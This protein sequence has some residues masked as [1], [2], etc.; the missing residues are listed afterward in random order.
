[1]RVDRIGNDRLFRKFSDA[2]YKHHGGRNQALTPH[3]HRSHD[4]G[5]LVYFFDKGKLV[6]NLS[7]NE[8]QIESSQHLSELSGHSSLDSPQPL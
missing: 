4:T 2:Q 5:C 1:M 7:E 8:V 3:C 6:G